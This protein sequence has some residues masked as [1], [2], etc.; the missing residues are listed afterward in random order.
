[1]LWRLASAAAY[2]LKHKVTCACCMEFVSCASLSN[3]L[4]WGK[5]TG[6]AIMAARTV[7]DKPCHERVKVRMYILCPRS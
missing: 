5:S 1:M 3:G 7:G 4:V 6:A 2:D